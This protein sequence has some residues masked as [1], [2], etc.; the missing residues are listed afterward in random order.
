MLPRYTRSNKGDVR[1]RDSE[2]LHDFSCGPGGCPDLKHVLLGQFGITVRGAAS[3]AL[4]GYL[5]GHVFL[6]W[7]QE[8]M[9]RVTAQSNVA[10]VTDARPMKPFA[11]RNFSV[12]QDPGDLHR[13][14][15]LP[16]E[17]VLPVAVP[18]FARGPQPA[19]VRAPFIDMAPEAGGRITPSCLSA[20][21]CR[22]VRSVVLP[23]EFAQAL[24]ADLGKVFFSHGDSFQS[25]RSGFGRGL[26][27][28]L[29][30]DLIGGLFAEG[31]NA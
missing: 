13:L 23:R 1:G 11:F 28:A 27:S 2:F 30:S 16:A 8:Q 20:A 9:S 14:S 15:L 21:S 12:R 26:V 18:E 7:G 29:E 19:F 6:V 5:I 31:H 17:E 22:A 10:V 3:L 25:L 4:L 24:G